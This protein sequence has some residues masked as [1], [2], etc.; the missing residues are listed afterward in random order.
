MPRLTFALCLALATLAPLAHVRRAAAG[1]GCPPGCP[2]CTPRWEDK[3]SK[4]PKYTMSCAPECVRGRDPWCEHGRC[5]EDN[6]PPGR[7]FTKKKLFKTEEDKVERILK[8]DVAT[9][10]NGACTSPSC[11]AEF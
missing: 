7:M 11:A 8:Y 4:K 9:S 5:P 3:K 2:N 6:S 1:E 10:P